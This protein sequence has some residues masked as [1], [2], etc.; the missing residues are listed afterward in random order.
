MDRGRLRTGEVFALLTHDGSC[1][2]AGWSTYVSLRLCLIILLFFSGTLFSYTMMSAISHHLYRRPLPACRRCSQVFNSQRWATSGGGG[3]RRPPK[4]KRA[5]NAAGK[6]LLQKDAKAVG[7]L[8]SKLPLERGVGKKRKSSNNRT[9]DPPP[10][11]RTDLEKAPHMQL[12]SVGKKE[13]GWKEFMVQN[14]L[15]FAGIIFPTITMAV[16]VMVKPNLRAQLFGGGGAGFGRFNAS[17]ATPAAVYESERGDLKKEEITDEPVVSV[18]DTTPTSSNKE[19]HSV[20]ESKDVPA[21]G[22]DDYE[23]TERKST[24][25]DLFRAIGIRPHPSDLEK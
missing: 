2:R 23:M 12:E 7:K 17:K 15:L 9:D 18:E 10:P 20:E 11:V 5:Q 6:K 8:K 16:L 22:N 1:S 14:P 19:T 25:I 4:Q 13:Q 3:G 21:E 24:T